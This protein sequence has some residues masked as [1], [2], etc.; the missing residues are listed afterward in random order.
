MEEVKP[1]RARID[2]ILGVKKEVDGIMAVVLFEDGHHELISTRIL[3]NKCPK[4]LPLNNSM[5]NYPKGV[6]EF[7]LPVGSN[8]FRNAIFLKNWFAI[9]SFGTVAASH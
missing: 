8:G 3:V 5:A 1:K 6:Q 9:E 7:S 2:R 4:V